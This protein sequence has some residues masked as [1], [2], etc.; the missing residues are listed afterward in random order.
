MAD[1]VLPPW[2]GPTLFF[3]VL[4]T[5]IGFFMFTQDDQPHFQGP[6]S[7]AATWP[8]VGTTLTGHWGVRAGRGGALEVGASDGTSASFTVVLDSGER[9]EVEGTLTGAAFTGRVSAPDTPWDDAV[10]EL[11]VAERE[12]HGNLRGDGLE[13]EVRFERE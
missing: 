10:V 5:I 2:L 7:P 6:P 3:V 9:F 13:D 1:D 8:P 12:L 4:A 11:E